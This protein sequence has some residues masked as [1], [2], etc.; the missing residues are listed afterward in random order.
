MV[1]YWIVAPGNKGS[2]PFT[3]LMKW[4]FIK[5]KSQF[6]SLNLNLICTYWQNYTYI[7][8]FKEGFLFD[9]LY[10][11][12]L[13][14]FV[15][16]WITK[17]A[18]LVNFSFINSFYLKLYYYLIF[19]PILQSHSFLN[20]FNFNWFFLRVGVLISLIFNLIFILVIILNV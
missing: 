1:K 18:L 3:Y 16:Y 10:K 15:F 19:I 7:N 12:Y 8:F 17:G 6:T 5:I 13:D 14:S 4:W 11:S 20:I 2:T 9:H